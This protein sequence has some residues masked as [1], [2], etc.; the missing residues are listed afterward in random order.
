V[1]AA[2]AGVRARLRCLLIFLARICPPTSAS[3]L[4]WGRFV[5]RRPAVLRVLSALWYLRYA[6]V[7][8][9][10]SHLSSTSH[11]NKARNNEPQ[12]L[13]QPLCKPP[14]AVSTTTTSA[15]ELGM[16]ARKKRVLVTGCSGSLGRPVCAWLSRRGHDVVG[17]DCFHSPELTD[18]CPVIVGNICDVEAVAAAMVNV[19][20]L[21]HLAAFPDIKDAAGKPVDFVDKLLMPNVAGLYVCVEAALQAGV[22]RV[23]L[24]SS[25]QVITGL[26][27]TADVDV[28]PK[29]N[30][31]ALGGTE[32]FISSALPSPFMSRYYYE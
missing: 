5:L 10:R 13:Q 32:R 12:P 11:E 15:D 9:A 30:L 19:E 16:A 18:V 8:S 21:I 1:V 25:V 17:F 24:A 31:P 22:W 3:E 4:L 23:V 6:S 26:T 27:A 20:V 2:A 28:R 14:A 7:D 29:P